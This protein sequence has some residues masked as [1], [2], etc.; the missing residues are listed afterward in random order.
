MSDSKKDSRIASVRDIIKAYSAKQ[1]ARR[2]LK[3]ATAHWPSETE[4]KEKRE[5][6]GNHTYN[7]R[8]INTAID[9]TL[10]RRLQDEDWNFEN[11]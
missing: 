6:A 4:T 8:K 5:E 9:S 10:V 3:F 7:D 2:A 11:E 1:T